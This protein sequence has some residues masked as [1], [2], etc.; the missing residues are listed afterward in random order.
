M[1]DEL[2]GRDIMQPLPVDGKQTPG[3]V[4]TDAI[5][6]TFVHANHSSRAHGFS[7][8]AEGVP[9]SALRL[10]LLFY[11]PSAKT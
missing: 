3:D 10:M 9:A 11:L 8:L 6:D 2:H 5:P 7:T 1:A 4:R